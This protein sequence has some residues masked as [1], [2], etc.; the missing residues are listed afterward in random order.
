MERAEILHLAEQCIDEY[1][2]LLHIDP[3]FKVSVEIAD[4]EKIS[5][6]IEAE[7][8]AVWRLKLNPSMHSDEI[9]VQMSVLNA[10]LQILFRDVPHSRYREEVISKLTHAFTSILSECAVTRQ[11]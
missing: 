8:P 10:L 7:Q 5:E 2:D 1:K 3:Y 6:C 4:F 9:D 11:E